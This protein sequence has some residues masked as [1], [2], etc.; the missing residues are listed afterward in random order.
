MLIYISTLGLS[1]LI[2]TAI[3]YRD[4]H[5]QIPC[6]GTLCVLCKL[7]Y[8]SLFSFALLL[9]VV[10]KVWQ[11]V[12]LHPE[13]MAGG[14][15]KSDYT[16]ITNTGALIGDGVGGDDRGATHTILQQTSR[17]CG[18]YLHNLLLKPMSPSDSPL[19]SPAK[20]RLLNS[21]GYSRYRLQTEME[22]AR[23]TVFADHYTRKLTRVVDGQLRNYVDF[24]TDLLTNKWLKFAKS[25]HSH[26]VSRDELVCSILDKNA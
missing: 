16:G 17:A 9:L 8:S 18:V 25:S 1:V 26:T 19:E 4:K 2:S 22:A 6:V 24:N 20:S 7:A 14:T 12:V 11:T 21:T 10:S 15:F 3:L 23:M 13:R 5:K